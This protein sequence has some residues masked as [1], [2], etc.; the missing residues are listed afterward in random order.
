LIEEVYNLED[1]LVV[2]G[3]L[4]SFIRHADVVKIAN[5]AQI[6]N[7]IAPILTRGD[8]LLLQSVFY[9][10]E[11]FARRRNGISLR[12]AVAGPAYDSPAHGRAR[13]VDASAILD[14]DRLHVFAVNR[15][16]DE[17]AR[18]RVTLAGR[19]ITAIESAEIVSGPAAQ[20]A[21]SFEQPDVVVFR[22]FADAHVAGEQAEMELPRMSF[23]AC[24]IQL[25]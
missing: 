16:V 2:T 11:M 5:I 25:G 8:Q 13:Y 18:V 17:T 14:C 24:T 22:P 10:F 6:V 1:A 21:N 20:A 12:P 9:T 15:S 3:F 23:A 19:A 7:V 4:N